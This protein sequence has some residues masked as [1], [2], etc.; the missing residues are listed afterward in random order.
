TILDHQALSQPVTGTL[1]FTDLNAADVTFSRAGNDLVI[2]IRATGKTILVPGNFNSIGSDGI[3]QVRF[4][5]GTTW[6]RDRITAAAFY[7][8]GPGNAAVTAQDGPAT[9]VAGNGDDVLAGGN[10]DDTFV[11]A[12]ADGN[13]RIAD[14]Q[15]R[16]RPVTNTLRF[17]DLNAGDLTVSR[18]NDDLILAVNAT[19]RT[20]TVD[21]NFASIGEDGIQQIR[22]ADGTTWDRAQMTSEAWYR[23]GPDDATVVAETGKAKLVAGSGNDTLV[24]GYGNDT[25]VYAS[26][27]GNLTIRDHQLENR[28]VTN[29]L[30]LTDLNAGDLTFS[31][32]NNDLIITVVATGKT[33][34]VGGNFDSS[35]SDGIQQIEFADGVLWDRSRIEAAAFYDAGAGDV[36]VTAGGGDA[37]LVAG[38][39]DDTLVGGYGDDTFIY[40]LADGNLTI[41]D[42]QLPNQPVTNTLQLTDLDPG[43]LALSHSGDDLVIFV[44]ASGRTIKVAGNFGSVANDGIQRIAFANGTI[45]DRAQI[46]A[47]AGY[48]ANPG[49]HAGPLQWTNNTLAFDKGDGNVAIAALANGTVQ[50]GSDIAPGDVALQADAAGDLTVRILDGGDSITF[51]NDLTAYWWGVTSQIGQV[52]FANGLAIPLSRNYYNYGNEPL[53]FTWFGTTADKVLTGSVFGTNVFDLGPGG[54]T[55]SAGSSSDTFV[56]DKG[57]GAASIANVSGGTLRL[58]AD[59]AA[60][61]V[62]LQ[63][64]AAGDLT[65]RLLDTGESITFA[66]DLTQ[67]GW[68]VASRL[69]EIVFGD[70]TAVSLT[71]N[72]YNYGDEPLTFTWLGTGAATTFTG[73][74]FGA[75]V[76]DLGPGSDVVTAGSSSDSF[77]FGKG[78]G[79]AFVSNVSG[80]TL[81][82]RSDVAANDIILQADTAGDLTIKLRDSGDS[83]TFAND[84]NQYWWG[85]TSQLG[86]IAFADGTA[87]SLTRNFYNDS[88][89]P[90]TFTWF[91]SSADA[92][93]AGAAFGTNVFHLGA[94]DETV[95]AGSANDVFAF[96]KSDGHATVMN[97]SGGTLE[98]GPD[99]A[100]N[101]VVLQADAASDLTVRILDTGATITFTNDLTQHG[102]GVSSQLGQI[103]FGDGSSINLTRNVYNY[104]DELLTFT[105]FGMSAAATLTG[106]SL[107]TNVFDLGPGGD[108]VTAGS[109]NDIF[110]F[111]KGDGQATVSNVTGGTLRLGSDIEESDVALLAN[112]SG[113]L[114]VE[115]L[116]TG[117][118]LTF[119]GDLSSRS[120]SLASQLGTIALGDGTTLAM[121]ALL[122]L[123][124]TETDTGKTLRLGPAPI[125]T[126]TGTASDTALAGNSAGTNVFELGAGGDTVTAASRNDVF[127]FD[128][129]DGQASVSNVSGGTLRLASDIAESDAIL[130]V[131]ATGDLTIKLVD[132]GESITFQNDLRQLGWGVASQLGQIAF[133]DGTTLDL[134]RSYENGD[135]PLSFTWFGTTADRVLTGTSFGA[136]IFNLG[137]GGDAITAA[138]NQDT[139]VFGEGD[140]QATVTNVTG[141]TL[142]LASNIAAS[143]AVLQADANG[144]LT[145]S[146]VATGDSITFRNDL[147]Q[148]SWGVLSQLGQIVFGDGTRL[149][150]SRSGE[151]G[152][153]PLNFTWLGG[154]TASALAGTSFGANTFI[155]G[156]GGDTVVAGSSN[157]TFVFGKGDGAANVSN[158][159]GGTLQLA[160]GISASD[161]ALQADTAGDLT[162][163]LSAS[164]DSIT[165]AHD[166]AQSTWGVSSRLGQIAFADGTM[167][168]LSRSYENG[169]HPLS[170][171]LAGTPDNMT[172][173]GTS[174]GANV[175]RLGSGGDTITAGSS[176]D[177]FLFDEGDGQATVS[178]VS[179]GTLELASD[180][181][182][183]DVILQSDAGGDLIV[184]LADTGDS[185][186]FAADLAHQSWGVSSRVSEIVFGGGT[187]LSLTRDYS[188]AA[189]P[190]TF[191]WIGT[192]A[193]TTLTGTTFGANVFDLGPGG[194]AVM[195]ASGN[196]SFVFDK[197]DGQAIVSN[198]TGGVLHLGSDI[199][200]SD[201]MLQSGGN[202]DLT[203]RLRDTGESIT[204]QNDR[205]HQSFGTASALTRIVYGDGTSLDQG[206][207]ATELDTP[208]AA[209]M[210]LTTVQNAAITR[211]FAVTEQNPA[212]NVA[213]AIVTVPAKGSAVLNADGTFTY[214][215]TGGFYGLAYGDTATTTFTYRATDSHGLSSA[216]KTV[217]ITVV[218]NDH[219]PVASDVAVSTAPD[220]PVTHGFAAT[221]PDVGD[222]L[223]YT[224]VSGPAQGS[225][226]VNAD[227]TFTYDPGH[228][229]DALKPG[230][231]AIASFTYKAIDQN[232]LS[233]A[234]QTVTVTVE[235]VDHPPTASNVSVTT[236]QNA[237]VTHAFAAS[238]PDQGDTLTYAI[239]S[240]PTQGSVAVNA[241]GSFTFDPGHAFDALTRGQTATVS[242]TYQATDQGGLSSGVATVT[243]TVDGIDHA[244]VASD[245]AVTTT[246]DVPVT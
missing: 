234:V 174:F 230:Q 160:S 149:Q 99:I 214:D 228:A 218:G 138:F 16:D 67:Y 221:D 104:G 111:D 143:D 177:T 13:L 219:P 237:P 66:A 3:Q 44:A 134:N 236:P 71:R 34:T 238:D 36:T 213:Y 128:K 14:H 222:H 35:S 125:F 165:F 98:L 217:S 166:L 69:G 107:G 170:F 131:D 105:W 25:F 158:V 122:A 124:W 127:V 190:L 22:F 120:G 139:F 73:V 58:G 17:L 180:I 110:A 145:V 29:T 229:F 152:D 241:D 208:V 188:V 147:R 184:K 49:N 167:M 100:Q 23:A 137:I 1:L 198:V 115:L 85:V 215:P 43:D 20:I 79:H 89:E 201:V 57:D 50:L 210:S 212:D 187:A 157:D 169:D 193:E 60:S 224:V 206:G 37:T 173:V 191:T 94:G 113:D 178:N 245:V 95:T 153:R 47:A 2:A 53:P 80:G 101:D 76:F 225:A 202:G 240:G 204:L 200:A 192:A 42:R 28:T 186:T 6:T 90:L 207:M 74:S 52:A 63:A 91:G 144:D 164:G 199:A 93:L 226:A 159:S 11:Y 183:S 15:M 126:W 4:A 197:G 64:D 119:R 172:L 82:L 168:K 246:P 140:G 9:L 243:V 181:L 70:G 84:L 87:M 231:T 26:T 161:V 41:A 163:A 83:I 209:D 10:G 133:G 195:A 65:L 117:E 103:T 72:Y 176:N 220:Q 68:G 156:P 235:G 30:Q 12:A 109:A 232:G 116:D 142:R 55:V 19:G 130:Q 45:W 189:Q 7:L 24:G 27:D 88:A 59:V 77:V 121:S 118:S 61:D 171:T 129:G 21:G 39:G 141:G 48:Q 223:T 244:P 112:N 97:V 132:T 150:L 179:G 135:Q 136:N 86:Q 108:T 216:V 54:D 92:V 114:T 75:N 148:Y 106:S 33:I 203:L 239:V 233:S 155:L 31:R 123:P 194:D 185:I 242:F 211:A 102:W 56:F 5:D 175:F 151:N 146:L 38:P 62:V 154:P 18:V 162:V 78:D 81:R 8:A 182:A 51:T 196:D 40:G 96:D 227:G 32:V 46:A 205:A